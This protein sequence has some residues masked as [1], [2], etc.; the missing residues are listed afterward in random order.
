MQYLFTTQK[1]TIMNLIDLEEN[2]FE[3]IYRIPSMKVQDCFSEQTR[4]YL[5]KIAEIKKDNPELK[6]IS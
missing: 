6:E 4:N 2:E 5:L 1:E 3:V